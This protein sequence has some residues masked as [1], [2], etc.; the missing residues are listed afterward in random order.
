MA[1]GQSAAVIPDGA[2]VA[3]R[4]PL[5]EQLLLIHHL[6][7]D[8]TDGGPNGYDCDLVWDV[9]E[10]KVPELRRTLTAILVQEGFSH[11]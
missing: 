4:P 1:Q 8:C 2:C 6:R 5:T 3:E 10:T 7:H 9:I 11:P